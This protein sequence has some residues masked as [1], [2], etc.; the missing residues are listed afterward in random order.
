ME[1]SYSNWLYETAKQ[2][3]ERCGVKPIVI[4]SREAMGTH[5]LFGK[6][7]D[8]LKTGVTPTV[9]KVIFNGEACIVLWGDGEKTVVK[10][11]EGDAWNK[12][13]G[14]MA[15]FSKKLFGNDNT[16]NKVI[17]RFG[18]P[19]Y[20][21]DE[22]VQKAMEKLDKNIREYAATAD[23]KDYSKETYERVCELIKADDFDELPQESREILL[24]ERDSI[25]ATRRLLNSTY[26]TGK[27]KTWCSFYN[28]TELPE[29][30]QEFIKLAKKTFNI[31]L[32][33]VETKDDTFKIIIPENWIKEE[34]EDIEDETQE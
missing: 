34:R 26:M 4:G 15:A 29:Y 13:V 16:F 27:F 7:S 3:E 11:Q 19:Y 28:E 18:S 22:R 14:M 9:K 8:S 23:V 12:E 21:E 6:T 17:S 10:R 25:K 33:V 1:Q 30:A 31:D 20:N 32:K 24:E 5:G 2:L